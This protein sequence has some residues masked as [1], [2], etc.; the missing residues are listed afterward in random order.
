MSL[1]LNGSKTMS[2]AGTELQCIEIYTGE[3]YTL[4]FTFTYANTSPINCTGWTL[5]TSAKFYSVDTVT[6]PSAD[7]VELGNL[8]LLS[9]QP[10]TGSG[11]YAANLSA[12]FTTAASG[13]G[14]MYIPADLTGGTGTPNPTPTISLANSG[15]NSALVIVT[16]G[17]SRTDTL[18]SK[19]DFNKEPI[20][21][22]VR[23]Q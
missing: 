19:V 2:I 13:V 6:Y 8:S 3:S 22:I 16:L 17:V 5:S 20:G 14:Y 21:I 12:A 11:S 4:P 1:L 15:A 18:S 9:P 7:T 10:S 23:Y